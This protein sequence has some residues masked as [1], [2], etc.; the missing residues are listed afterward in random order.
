MWTAEVLHVSN[1]IMCLLQTGTLGLST[2]IGFPMA[3]IAAV[4]GCPDAEA[5]GG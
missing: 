3:R 5:S 1:C 4:L 2:C